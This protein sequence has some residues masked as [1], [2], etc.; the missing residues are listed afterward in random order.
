MLVE[1]T[2][3]ECSFRPCCP[4]ADF[5]M[6]ARL[7]WLPVP[8]QHTSHGRLSGRRDAVV[9]VDRSHLIKV[10]GAHLGRAEFSTYATIF[11]V[12]KTLVIGYVLVSLQTKGGVAG[13][14]AWCRLCGQGS[15]IHTTN[16]MQCCSRARATLPE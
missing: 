12:A 6:T 14:S 7:G 3:H 16:A 15:G 10:A 11:W 9:P 4:G 1:Q 13:V 5:M 2:H 8:A